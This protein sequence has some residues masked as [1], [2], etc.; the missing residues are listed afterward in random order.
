MTINDIYKVQKLLAEFVFEAKK[1]K[2][3]IKKELF[4]GA[5]EYMTVQKFTNTFNSIN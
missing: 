1:K 4:D 3:D 5:G 2:L